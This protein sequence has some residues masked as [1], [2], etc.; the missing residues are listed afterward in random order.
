MNRY[1]VFFVDAEQQTWGIDH[2][3]AAT[4]DAAEQW[5]L[6]HREY[7]VDCVAHSEDEMREMASTFERKST[8]EIQAEMAVFEGV[9]DE[10]SAQ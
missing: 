4:P 1:A 10:G 2:V 9:D 7:A 8:A 3:L 5:V 6:D